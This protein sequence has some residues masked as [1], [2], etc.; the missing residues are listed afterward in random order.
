MLLQAASPV[1]LQAASPVL[2]QASSEEAEYN[3]AEEEEEAAGDSPYMKLC[4]MDDPEFKQ[5]NRLF[6]SEVLCHAFPT[7]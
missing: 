1:L 7:S 3:Y 6:I 2:L 4:T 5:L